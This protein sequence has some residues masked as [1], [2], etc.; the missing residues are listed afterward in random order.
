MTDQQADLIITDPDVVHGRHGSSSAA[1]ATEPRR[2]GHDVHIVVEEQLGGERDPVI[3]A[4]VGWQSSPS[5]WLVP[6]PACGIRA[7]RQDPAGAECDLVPGP[8][9]ERPEPPSVHVSINALTER[10]L[11]AGPGWVQHSCG[12]DGRDRVSATPADLLDPV[13]G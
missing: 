10:L 8:S 1:P 12:H 3:T 11:A 5:S 9:A 4:L 6:E 2:P 13:D 7:T